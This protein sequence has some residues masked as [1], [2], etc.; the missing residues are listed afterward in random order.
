[1]T[2]SR[3]LF[4]IDVAT[5]WA[6]PEVPKLEAWKAEGWSSWGRQAILR[7]FQVKKAGLVIP[8]HEFVGTVTLI[9]NTMVISTCFWTAVVD[10]LQPVADIE[11]KHKQNQ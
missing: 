5:K 3:K 10:E 4:V 1:V 2:R 11:S 6:S 9:L 8:F 7:Q